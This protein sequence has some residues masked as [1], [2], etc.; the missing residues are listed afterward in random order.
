MNNKNVSKILYHKVLKYLPTKLALYLMYF[1]GYHRLLNLKNPKYYGEK[2]QWLKLY[3]NLDQ[4]SAYVDKYLVRKYVSAKIGNN[5]L[6]KL[7]GVYDNFDQ[8][9]FEKLPQRFVIK[10]NNGTESL[11]IC[12]NKNVLNY[13]ETKK[14]TEK[15]KKDDFYKVKKEFQYKNVKHKILIEE[16]L[17]DESGEL[18][19]Y[20]IYCF[21]GEPM[22]ISVFSGR[23]SDKRVDTYDEKGKLLKD[24]KNG[25]RKA[26]FSDNP[27]KELPRFEDMKNIAK[28]LSEPFT[29]VR[30][31]LYLVN[32][33]ILFG[34]LTFTD[35]AGSE[36][37]YPLDKYDVK[38]ADLIPLKPV[39]KER[40]SEK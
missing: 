15:W 17:E 2:I 39:I 22:W 4:L 29:C 26:K 31:D 32:G 25:S 5:H 13:Q 30:V 33:I 16:Y 11:I 27:P 24:F 1:R 19:D 6:V 21:N 23:F 7:L 36:G 34:E 3:G 14:L 38:F 40:K 20:K 35:G 37:M 28:V 8:I 18:K 9:D 10:S 12:K